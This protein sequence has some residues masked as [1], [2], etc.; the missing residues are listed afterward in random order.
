MM[1]NISTIAPGILP[2]RIYEQ[3]IYNYL[4]SKIENSMESD[5]FDFRDS[6]IDNS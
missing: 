3:R 4:I 6:F 1:E 5:A 2:D